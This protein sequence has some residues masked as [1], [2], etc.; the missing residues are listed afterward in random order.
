MFG[1]PLAGGD[2][3]TVAG[4]EGLRLAAPGDRDLA[5]DHHDSRVPIMRMLGVHLAG[6][7]AAIKDL[8]TLAPQLGLK[9]A[10]VHHRT[11]I[12]NRRTVSGHGMPATR[13]EVNPSNTR[14]VAANRPR[15]TPPSPEPCRPAPRPIAKSLQS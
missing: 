4:T 1:M 11:P 9:F 5:A 3:A 13:G 12:A 10:L 2:P 7:E 8:I 6:P 14:S 15:R